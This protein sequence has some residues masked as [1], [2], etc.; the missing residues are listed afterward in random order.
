MKILISLTIFFIINSTL[1]QS[2]VQEYTPQVAPPSPTAFEFATHGNIPLNGSSGGFSYSV[3]L[4]TIQQKDISVPI[5]VDYFSNGV[6]VDGLAGIVGTDWSLRAGGVVSRVMRGLP[7]ER[8]VT[9]WY[10]SQPVNLQL[11]TTIDGIWATAEGAS[12]DAEPDWFSFNVNGISGSFYFDENLVPHINSDQYLKI[13][14]TQHTIGTTYGKHSTFTI[15][16]SNGYKYIL[17]GNADYLEGNMSSR[18]CFVGPKD[19]YYSAWYLKEIISPANNKIYFSY[20]DNNLMYFTN[21]SYNLTYSQQCFQPL[22]TYQYSYSDCRYFNDMKSKVLSNIQFDNGNIEFTYNSNRLDGGG[23]SLK[24]MKVFALNNPNP[25]K[26]VSFTYNEI[27]NRNTVLDWKLE[28]NADLRYRTFLKN[29]TIKDGTSSPEEQKYIF[30]YYEENK[31]PNRLSFSKDKFG[32]NNGTSNVRPFSS[33]LSTIFPIWDYMQSYGGT[34]F[35]TANLE[36]SPDV[37]H[38]GMLEKITYPTGGYSHVEYEANSNYVITPKLVYNNKILNVTKDCNEPAGTTETFTFVANGTPLNFSASGDLDTY[39][40]N[41]TTDP[42]PLHDVYNV[43]IRKNG[44]VVL[45]LGRDYGTP[46]SSNPDRTCVSTFIPPFTYQR[47]PICT[48]AGS[49]YEVSISLNSK[50]WNPAYGVV[51]ITYNAETVYEETPFYGS[52]ARVK[53]IVDYNE[54]GSYNKKKY[55]YN[56]FS[57]YPSNKTTMSTTYEPSYYETGDFWL[58]CPP[59]SDDDEPTS[60]P[61]APKF[62]VNSSSITS[63]FVSRNSSTNY[64]VIT[65]ILDNG[66]TNIGAIEKHYNIIED[67][68]ANHILGSPIFGTPQ[69]NYSSNFYYDKVKEEIYYDAQKAPVGKKMFQYQVLDE[70]MLPGFVARKNFDFPEGS[71]LPYNWELLNYSASYYY[72]YFGTIKL[73]EVKEESYLS[74]GTIQ[75]NSNYVYGNSPYFGLKEQITTNSLGETLRTDYSYPQDGL[76]WQ[77]GIMNQMIEKNMI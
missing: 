2:G 57:E 77:T 56:K 31:L 55:F 33:K 41:C 37:V 71:Y 39:N 30:D 64:T 67:H 45:S 36:V 52:G 6:R 18:D 46:V 23:K 3:P 47:D 49:T 10:P 13:E 65:E 40:P 4:Y 14:F 72:N 9:T 26:V 42:D 53:Q 60:H 63:Q 70:G 38:Y 19:W 15:T 54:E 7:D 74:N 27:Q 8:A 59:R 21:A 48:E 1:A 62:T 68:A 22:N 12:H 32:F 76:H 61:N 50:P 29:M 16:D 25:L 66:N 69:S 35:A 11:Q 73:K 44:I 17:G 43:T 51:N 58:Y 75:T 20:A 34:G 5:S 24:E 28:G